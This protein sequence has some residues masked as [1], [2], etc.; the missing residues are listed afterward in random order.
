MWIYDS[1]NYNRPPY[2]RAIFKKNSSN[3]VITKHGCDPKSFFRQ[4]HLE[5]ELD[6]FFSRGAEFHR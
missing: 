1:E 5:S 4:L 6:D 2:F 3:P